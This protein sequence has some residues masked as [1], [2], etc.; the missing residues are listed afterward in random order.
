VF[1]RFVVGSDSAHHRSLTGI[2]GETRLLR[3]KG[4]LDQYQV[5]MLEEIYAWLNT[6]LP[7]PPFSS[8]L[9]PKDAVGWFKDDA[10]ESLQKM[11]EIVTILKKHG[12]PVRLL[13][14]ANPGKILYEDSYQVVVEEWRNL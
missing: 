3:D 13:R 4:I 7:V 2:I 11:W 5:S 12:V 6:N 1:I 8:G 10:G 14:S 9:W